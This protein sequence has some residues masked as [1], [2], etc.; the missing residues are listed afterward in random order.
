MMEG[1]AINVLNMKSTHSNLGH[2][3]NAHEGQRGLALT[4]TLLKKTLSKVYFPNLLTND[5][6]DHP[7]TS[8]IFFIF[9]LLK[10]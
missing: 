2:A 8:D 10:V 1:G 6:L 3:E 4:T 5:F 9:T 7:K